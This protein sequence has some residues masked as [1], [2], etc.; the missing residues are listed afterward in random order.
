M[1]IVPIVKKLLAEIDIE[2]DTEAY[3]NRQ[4]VVITK[5]LNDSKIPLNN[6]Q[7]FGFSADEMYFIE[8]LRHNAVNLD[9]LYIESTFAQLNNAKTKQRTLRNRG[10]SVFNERYI[11]AYFDIIT[12]LETHLENPTQDIISIMD[13]LP[14]T[15]KLKTMLL[16]GCHP[17]NVLKIAT[18]IPL[19][20]AE[21]NSYACE[22]NPENPQIIIQLLKHPP[23]RIPDPRIPDPRIPVD[24]TPAESK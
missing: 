14:K 17:K 3:I 24:R 4:G 19:S 5:Y 16:A 10:F 6:L 20:K 2:N 15:N 23:P 18:L 13:Q 12:M 9:R 21:R 1:S 8:I 11:Y 7:S 22:I